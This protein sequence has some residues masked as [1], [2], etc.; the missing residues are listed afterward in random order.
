[1]KY[2]NIDYNNK[3]I[4]HQNDTPLYVFNLKKIVKKIKLYSTNK[5]KNFKTLFSVK[6]CFEKDFLKHIQ[7]FVDGY[8]VANYNEFKQIQ[9][10]NLKNKIVSVC[11]PSYNNIDIKKIIKQSIK[12]LILVFD[13]KEQFNSCKGFLHNSNVSFML[14][15]TENHLNNQSNGHYGFE[16]K[17][18]KELLQHKKF[19]GTH[20]HIPRKSNMR[21][22]RNYIKFYNLSLKIPT[23]KTINFGG[24]QHHY[25]WFEFKKKLKN[26]NI[27]YMIEPGQPFFVDCIYGI[28]KVL[29]IKK[30]GSSY[31]V[32]T[33]LSELCHLQWSRDKKLIV[34]KSNKKNRIELYGPA[35]STDDYHGTVLNDIDNFK[36]NDTVIFSNINPLSLPLSREFNGIDKA[37]IVW[38]KND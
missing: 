37:K 28:G 16:L 35:C 4:K 36:V 22:I 2:L 12:S 7:N 11:G 21:T 1:M 30:R 24:G 8:D 32:I 27:T 15:I 5:P 34:K 29:T 3:K 38:K 9:Q 26:K 19:I 17:E 14:R 20:I 13:N 31:K 33:N 25:N 18:V 10:L 6:S 23:V